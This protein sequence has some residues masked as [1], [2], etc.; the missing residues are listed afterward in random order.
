MT[1]E[2]PAL[3]IGPHRFAAALSVFSARY[4]RWAD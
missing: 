1:R 4:D 2:V 3:S